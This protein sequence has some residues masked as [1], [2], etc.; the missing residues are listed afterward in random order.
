MEIF[1]PDL[2]AEHEIIEPYS[3][4]VPGDDEV[5]SNCRD[6]VHCSIAEPNDLRRHF[7]GKKVLI[8]FRMVSGG[9]PQDDDAVICTC[10]GLRGSRPEEARHRKRPKGLAEIFP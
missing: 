9:I 4:V 1:K 5:R 3:A 7:L 10:R 2:E 6:M 8:F